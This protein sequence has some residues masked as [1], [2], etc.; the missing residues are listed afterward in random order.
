M[1]QQAF[2]DKVM[3]FKDKL[4]RLALRLLVSKDEAEDAVQE[5]Y[6]KLWKQKHKIKEYKNPEAY[7]MTMTKNYCLDR[8]KSGQAS[9]I[10]I[11]H[12]N[13]DDP[14][15]N[16]DKTT[17]IQDSM[18]LV[19]KLIE[20][21]PEQQRLLIQL[22]DIEAYEYDEISEITGLKQGTLRVN[23][24]RARK[25]IRERLTQLHAYEHKTY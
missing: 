15:Q 17:D 19:H 7:A 2:I 5:V 11:V 13:Y 25:T 24:S 1:Q 9:N 3:P 21:L 22:R 18:S 23:L 14:N 8:L 10:R 20:E 16:L 4:F 12:S 6:L